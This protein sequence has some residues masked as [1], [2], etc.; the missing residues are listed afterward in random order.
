MG[1]AADAAKVE[2][3]GNVERETEIYAEVFAAQK[4]PFGNSRLAAFPKAHLVCLIHFTTIHDL[5]DHPYLSHLAA[6]LLKSMR[7]VSPS[8]ITVLLHFN[9]HYLRATAGGRDNYIKCFSGLLTAGH[10]P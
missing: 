10:V 7:T 9:S 4:S 6:S 2:S 1:P 5:L 8:F 3:S